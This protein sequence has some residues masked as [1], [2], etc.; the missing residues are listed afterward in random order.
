MIVDAHYHLEPRLEPVDRLLERMNLHGMHRTALILTNV[1][2]FEM[3]AVA[4]AQRVHATIGEQDTTAVLST[5]H[6]GI[7]SSL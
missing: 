5:R 1:N 4:N 2:R 6:R 7:A 3:A